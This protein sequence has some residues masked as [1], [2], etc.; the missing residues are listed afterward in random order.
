M[1]LS[2]KFVGISVAGSLTMLLV[3]TFAPIPA[4]IGAL[5]ACLSVLS[6][7]FISYV[8][9]DEEREKRNAAMLEKLKIPISLAPE[10]EL[11]EKYD[12]FSEAL[13]ALAKQIDPVLRQYALLKLAS[14]TEEVRLLASGKVVFSSTESWR[15]VYDALLQGPD[16]KTYKSVSWVKTRSYWRDQPG[17]Q[18]MQANFQAAK[19]GVQIERIVILGSNL[20]APTE[21]LPVPEVKAWVD[22]QHERGIKVLLV[23]ES[24]IRGEAD[25]LCDFG[26][27]GERATGIQE[28]DEQSRTVRF[29]L[30]FDKQ[31]IRPA[32]DRWERLSLYATPYADLLALQ[33]RQEHQVRT[34]RHRKQVA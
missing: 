7:L 8:E 1:L 20:W 17:R 33:R 4:Q 22:E 34:L 32:Q 13:S 29:I 3:C 10:R 21:I 26:I 14:I 31:S 25:L 27:Y 24:E 30:M 23:R 9:Q 15:T 19:R 11:F 5:G 2:F 16:L 28:L 12:A 6:G 18:S